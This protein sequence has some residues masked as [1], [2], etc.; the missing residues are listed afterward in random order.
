MPRSD[1][2]LNNEII[3]PTALRRCKAVG[4]LLTIY[5][6]LLK[7]VDAKKEKCYTNSKKI[8]GMIFQ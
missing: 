7:R 8:N 4:F 1:G 3:N 5:L 6:F 2:M